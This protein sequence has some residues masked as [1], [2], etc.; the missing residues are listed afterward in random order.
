MHDVSFPLI[1]ILAALLFLV[2]PA[3]LFAGTAEEKASES[4]LKAAFAADRS[5]P[6]AEAVAAADAAIASI[7]VNR[8]GQMRE[9][10]WTLMAQMSGM[11]AKHLIRQGKFT[12]ATGRQATAWKQIQ[13]AVLASTGTHWTSR[14]PFPPGLG[15]KTCEIILRTVRYDSELLS[16]SARNY[17]ALELLQNTD[18]QATAAGID[19][20]LYRDQLLSAIADEYRFLGH[21]KKTLGVLDRI[22]ERATPNHTTGLTARFNRAYWRSQYE[23]PQPSFL[24]EARTVADQIMADG[25]DSHSGSTRR[26]LAKMA[27]AYREAGYDIGILSNLVDEAEQSGDRMEAIYARRDL[28]DQQRML[29]DFAP[30]EANL[31]KAL[32]EVRSLGRKR[33]EPTLYR[34]YGILLRETGRNG[35]AIRMLHE[36]LRQ[37]R[38]YGWTQ[39]LPGLLHSLALAQ[40]AAGDTGGLRTTLAELERLI[41]SG[42]LEDD[43]QM[44][45]GVGVAVCLQALGEPARSRDVLDKTVAAARKAGVPA[46]LVRWAEQYRLDQVPAAARSSALDPS[47]DLQPLSIKSVALPGEPAHGR[48]TLSNYSDRTASGILTVEGA[49]FQD[50]W[51]PGTSILQ[52]TLQDAGGKAS[53]Q[54]PFIL[55]P[56]EE[57][58]IQA[59]TPNGKPAR[60]KLA[61]KGTGAVAAPPSIWEVAKEEDGSPE[62]SVTNANL[63]RLNAFYSVRIYHTLL[64]RGGPADR[65]VNFRVSASGPVYVELW[66]TK[67]NSLLAVDATGNGLFTDAGDLLLGDSDHDGFPD[68]PC[69]PGQGT[70]LE[71]RVFPVADVKIAKSEIRLDIQ[72]S[73]AAGWETS[74][75]NILR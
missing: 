45:A 71:L 13:E 18:R 4:A 61:W 46:W 73:G 55:Q 28:A 41:S 58:V 66:D 51:D 49:V 36:A 24:E 21:W 7:R 38:S 74:A 57:I 9:W 50:K 31:L 16:S 14:Q 52:V 37:T 20:D 63:A 29:S 12:E 69:P 30:A 2:P 65:P 56:L 34:Q 64:R 59:A 39:H 5:N 8:D 60:L 42:L 15:E 72:L 53:A 35:E 32:A 47:A 3:T 26:I 48:F 25:R 11:A 23:G 17:D 43:R 40:A 62:V 68:L 10:D 67:K 6:P 22:V 75:Q 19:G 44:D 54:H 33:S 27:F 70:E 1:R